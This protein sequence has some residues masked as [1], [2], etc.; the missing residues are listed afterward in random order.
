MNFYLCG[1]FGVGLWWGSGRGCCFG[2]RVRVPL[3]ARR[4]DALMFFHNS[5]WFWFKE[6]HGRSEMR[7]V[8]PAPWPELLTVEKGELW[9]ITG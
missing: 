4:R 6:G 3:R 7:P 9:E 2:M 1:E 8:G 5:F